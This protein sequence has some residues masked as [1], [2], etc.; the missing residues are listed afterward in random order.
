MADER[1]IIMA[2]ALSCF[3]M[4]I[5][6]LV[7]IVFTVIQKRKVVEKENQYIVELKNKEL[8]IFQKEIE[9]QEEERKKI[10]NNIHD[11]INPLIAV[12]NQ[13]ISRLN[14]SDLSSEKY[15]KIINDQKEVLLLMGKEIGSI[16]NDLSPRSV[17]HYGLIRALQQFIDVSG[18]NIIKL[19]YNTVLI[20]FINKTDELNIYRILFELIQN[21]RKHEKISFLSLDINVSESEIS[22]EFNH[23]GI[24]ISQVE[25]YNL[26]QTS[27]GLGINSLHSRVQLM[28]GTIEYS[29]S[30]DIK[31]SL[32]VPLLNE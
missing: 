3:V 4:F 22:V 29:K 2:V 14:D 27:A 13:N 8:L 5:M 26:L 12:L 15:T 24:G 18:D 20:N 1:S 30:N 9:T 23:D 25:F 16:T 17:N 19:N 31:V 28:H 21:I 11:E 32:K 7:I 6:V 10:A